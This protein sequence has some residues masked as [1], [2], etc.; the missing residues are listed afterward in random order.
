MR[1]L[2]VITGLGFGGA[3]QQLVTLVRHL[4]VTCEVASLTNPGAVAAALRRDGVPVHHVGMHGNADLTALPRLIQLIRQGCFDIVHTH[5][6]RA[7]LYGRIAAR[8]AGVPAV[9][10]TEHS[11]N[12][13]NIEGRRPSRGVRAL[14]RVT[15]RLGSATVAV[16]PHVE[17]ELRRW[18]VPE[19]RV[20]FIPNGVDLADFAFDPAGRDEFRRAYGLD[21]AEYL[22]GAV[23]RLVEGK[24]F[25]LL[26]SAFAQAVAGGG[27]GRLVVVGDGPLRAR[28]QEQAVRLGVAERVVFTGGLADV[29]RALA[30][31]DLFAAPSQAETF[32]LAVVEA[33]ASGLPV[34]YSA[35]PALESLPVDAAPGARR[36]GP[37]PAAWCAAL[38]SSMA[39]GRIRHPVPPAVRGYDISRCS[40][41]LVRLYQTH[42]GAGP[43][44]APH[45]S[46]RKARR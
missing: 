45:R 15:E 12:A 7:C 30:A 24:R 9:I 33:L 28:L 43:I 36:I 27:Q 11:L 18:G 46:R 6:Y 19:G 39:R 16:S 17:I 4:P 21:A 44:P 5:L 23:G 13:T 34:L 20:T 2:H 14:Y 25:D 10:A 22:V 42:A 29:P 31:M 3:E 26:I 35:C 8:I 32:G 37:D 38:R 41:E 1:V 40:D